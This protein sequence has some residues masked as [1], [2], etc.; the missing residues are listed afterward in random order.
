MGEKEVIVVEDEEELWSALN[1]LSPRRERKRKRQENQAQHEKEKDEEF[2]DI[3]EEDLYG[4]G[5]DPIVYRRSKRLV[6]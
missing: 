2:E 6:K 5:K 1:T 3:E 4:D